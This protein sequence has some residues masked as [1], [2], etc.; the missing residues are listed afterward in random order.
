LQLQLRL[1]RAAHITS[2]GAP[3]GSPL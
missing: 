3:V 1:L 2:V